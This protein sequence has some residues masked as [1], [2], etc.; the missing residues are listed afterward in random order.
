[1]KDERAYDD[2]YDDDDDVD[3]DDND[4]DQT[5]TAA[6]KA[7]AVAAATPTATAATSG[8]V[9]PLSV[10]DRRRRR[11]VPFKAIG[12]AGRSARCGACV[13]SPT[14]VLCC[15]CV[16]R[17]WRACGVRACVRA[18][19]LF[20][21]GGTLLAL[22]RRRRSGAAAVRPAWRVQAIWLLVGTRGQLVPDNAYP[23]LVLGLLTFIPG[24]RAMTMWRR[25]RRWWWL[26]VVVVVTI[27]MWSFICAS[28]D[29]RRT[30][31]GRR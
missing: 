24:A 22:V 2:D 18:V 17:V 19:M 10:L 7:A 6:K 8:G 27:W 26:V 25:R 14:R 28:R 30:A 23:L 15:V 12:L 13:A 11:K 5:R 16:A 3:D 9:E 20:S 29:A 1:M 4:D 31:V 21:V